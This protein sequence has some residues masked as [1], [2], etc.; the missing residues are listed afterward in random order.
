[1]AKN[2]D[3]NIKINGVDTTLKSFSQ[4]EDKIGELKKQLANAEFGSKEFKQTQKDLEGLQGAY[5]KTKQST[6]GWLEN[7]AQAP[8]I[9]GT[10]GQSIKGAQEVFSNLDMA[11]KTSAIGLL[12]TIVTQLIEKFS[13][14][15]GVLDP[16][17]KITSIFSGVMEKLANFILPPISATLEAIATGAEKVANFF[18]GLVG[19][20]KDLGD[21]LGKVAEEYDRLKD[22]QAQYELGI[23]KANAKLAEARDAAADAN[24]PIAE[25]KK[26]LQEAAKIEDD[27]AEKG[28]TRATEKAKNQAVELAISLGLDEK[29]IESLKTAN[30]QELENFADTIQNIKGLNREK[31]DALYQSIAVAE[32]IAAQQAKISKKTDTAI[33]GLDKEAEAAQKEKDD[34]AKTAADNRRAAREKELDAM[35]ELEKNKANSDIKVIEKLQEEKLQIQL[36]GEKKSKAEIDAIR[37]KDKKDREDEAKNDLKKISD[38]A[39]KEVDA[40]N[41]IAA[42]GA[43]KLSN[44]L[45]DAR[46]KELDDIEIALSKG[47]ITEEQARDKRFAAEQ[48]FLEKSKKSLEDNKAEEI[49]ILKE[50]EKQLDPTEYAKQK[51]AIEQKYDDQ[52]LANKRSTSALIVKDAVDRNKQLAKDAEIAAVQLNSRLQ[53]AGEEELNKAQARGVRRFAAEKAILAKTSKEVNANFDQQVKAANGNADA[54]KKI[55]ENRTKFNEKNANANKAITKDEQQYKAQALAAGANALNQAAELLGKDTVAGKAAAIAS[56]TINTYQSAIAAYKS[57]AGI[58]IVGPALGGI[59][60]ALAVATGLKAVQQITSTPV[61]EKP[62]MSAGVAETKASASKFATG[63]LLFGSSHD[64]GGIKTSYGELEGGEFVINK[65]STQSFLPV[66]S[67]IN[68]AGNARYAAGGQLPNMD[69]LKDVLANQNQN[70]QPQIIKTYVVASDVYSQA[71]ADK[72]IS[73][74]ARL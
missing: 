32:D 10:F 4:V 29:R 15:E 61:P 2:L 60:A 12:V 56:T 68:A 18:S 41:K 62:D 27:I 33:R 25:R 17:E 51:L 42:D 26:A 34:K 59:A 23:S 1:M 69:D 66:L 48:D 65:R 70:Q 63:G 52:L 37:A 28:K 55:E 46:Q 43:K 57:L 40:K 54:I 8:G 3:I 74:L 39:Q 53:K 36:K 13:K 22:T 38:D 49:R 30:A 45:Q 24:K 5:T 20:S 44:T 71:Q 21:Q 58:P 67:A 64:E 50:K 31:S 47:L 9:V 14:M 19:G 72:K 7:I 6:Q 11:F 16:L 35:I 73:N